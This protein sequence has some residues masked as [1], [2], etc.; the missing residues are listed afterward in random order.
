MELNDTARFISLSWCSR[1][2]KLASEHPACSEA[3]S[4]GDSKRFVRSFWGTFCSFF[5]RVTSLHCALH[6]FSVTACLACIQLS[7]FQVDA[8][9]ETFSGICILV[10]DGLKQC[11]RW[12]TPRESLS[13]CPLPSVSAASTFWFK[14]RREFC[15]CTEMSCQRQIHSLHLPYPGSWS[16]ILVY[17]SSWTLLWTPD[18][19]ETRAGWLQ[20]TES[21]PRKWQCVRDAGDSCVSLVSTPEQTSSL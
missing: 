6:R 2:W 15:S 3:T 5:A 18:W 19:G 12:M 17:H 4:S 16:T 9:K 14:S 7:L 8:G 21:G 1:N 20:G 11:N 13:F 10:A